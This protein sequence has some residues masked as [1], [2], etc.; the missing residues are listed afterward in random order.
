M[1]E[2]QSAR[3]YV[4]DLP[5]M[6][7]KVWIRKGIKITNPIVVIGLPGLG[8]IGGIISRYLIKKLNT[9]LVGIVTSP[10]FSNQVIVSRKGIARITGVKMYKSENTLGNS[11]LLVVTAD[12]HLENIWGE[13]DVA[14]KMLRFLIKRGVKLIV[15]VGGHVSATE[16]RGVIGFASRK[17]LLRMLEEAGC[18]RAEMGTPVVGLSGIILGLSSI[19]GIDAVCVLGETVSVRPDA[20]GSRGVLNV[21]NKFLGLNIDISDFQHEEERINEIISR[22]ESKVK[23]LIQDEKA[24]K[25]AEA[26]MPPDYVS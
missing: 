24:R 16:S 12:E 18:R 23:Q 20:E 6:E 14:L 9:R 10:Y 17:E 21:L 4:K 5:L 2:K 1:S 7:T 3:I 19:M 8:R 13:Y 25:I 11:D 26:F 22:Y 15:T